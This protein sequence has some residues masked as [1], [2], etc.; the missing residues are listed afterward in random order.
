[1]LPH[2]DDEVDSPSQTHDVTYANSIDDQLHALPSEAKTIQIMMASRARPTL[3]R[4]S[5]SGAS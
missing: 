1:M 5:G 4:V 3:V 2:F